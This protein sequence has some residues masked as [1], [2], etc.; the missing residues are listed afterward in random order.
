MRWLAVGLGVASLVAGGVPGDAQTPE[1][2]DE[3]CVVSA[4]N[5][6]APVQ[7]DGS[8]VLP[9]VP[10][11]LGPV[12]V[13]ATCVRDGE[14]TSGQSSLVTVPLDDVVLVPDIQFEQPIAI[15]QLLALSA[16]MTTLDALGATAQIT[17][18]GIFADG[19]QADLTAEESGTTYSVSNPAIL[20][21]DGD[22]QVTALGPG[23]AL[24]SALHE[25]ALG[26]LRIAVITSG[27]SDGDGM[28][29]DFEIANGFD[30]D[31]PA[32][33][34]GDPD[35]DGLTNLEEFQGGLDPR[36]P[37]T[38]GDGLLDGE[39]GG[40]GTDPLLFDT[41]G[42]GFSDGLEVQLGTD[43]L[44]PN[45]FDLAAGLTSIA[46][47]PDTFLLTFNTLLGDTSTQLA[48][49][50]TLIDGNSI[51]LTVRGTNYTSSDLTICNFGLDPG[52]IFAG[53]DG[54]CTITASNSGFSA[55]ATS[56][57]QGFAPT[58][59]GFVYIPGFAHNVDVA[60]DL[61]YVAAG[62]AGIRVVDVSDRTAP[63][64]AGAL[65]TPGDAQ[66]IKLIGEVAYVADGGSG[67]A[68]IDVSDPL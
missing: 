54:S 56:T 13:R 42:D 3:S 17:V 9:D 51:D 45:D 27:D 26:V 19:S 68:V 46:V 64:I 11:A 39:E 49:T 65:D 58:A 8:W 32:D 59:L 38:D 30:P 25:G 48:V 62:G 5:R 34:F 47:T 18:S 55:D 23:V 16:P 33:A 12:R 24:I 37:D 52:R 29:D 28:P 14:T 40:F 36:D 4:F 50:G 41:D 53:L 43:P 15:P 66:D 60:G 61:A 35:T 44:D 6:T 2:L 22:G 63:Q 67:L 10:T 1:P 21:L 31:N 20:G 57:V 7:A